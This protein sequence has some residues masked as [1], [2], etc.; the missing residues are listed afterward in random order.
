M[1]IGISTIVDTGNDGWERVE[2]FIKLG[3]KRIE[4]Q[5]KVNRFR[6]QYLPSLIQMIKNNQIDSSIH[7]LAKNFFYHDQIIAD[8]EY[9][10]LK[11]EI[12]IISIIGG[13][14][15]I[16]HIDKPD[17]LNSSDKKKIR[18]LLDFA[19]END[20]KLCLENSSRGLFAGNYLAELLD[21]F[22][23]LYF[24]LDIGHLNVALH[25]NDVKD[26]EQFLNLIKNRILQLHVSYNDGS[27][28]EHKELNKEGQKYLLRILE[29]LNNDKI[30]LLVETKNL[31]QALKVRKFLEKL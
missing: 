17:K 9:Y 10:R 26:L 22:K 3:F 24:C 12:R 18:E 6:T 1:K 25:N 7:S 14:R 31:K 15:V 4:F 8:S 16:F 21:E 27:G 5:T 29:I 11:A 19:K 23:D 13:S 20:I 2:D 28:D 30:D